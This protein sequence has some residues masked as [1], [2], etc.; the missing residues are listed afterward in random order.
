MD[1]IVN[2]EHYHDSYDHD[3][4]D[5]NDGDDAPNWNSNPKRILLLEIQIGQ[6]E[7]QHNNHDDDDDGED[8][9]DGDDG[10]AIDDDT[11]CWKKIA[12]ANFET[13]VICLFAS[14]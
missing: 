13:I 5:D 10:A 2:D 7:K 14:H 4:D 6:L 1:A 12:G 9:D 8:D 3:D 11:G